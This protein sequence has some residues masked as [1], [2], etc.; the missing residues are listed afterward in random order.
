M[1][2][3]L[4]SRPGEAGQVVGGPGLAGLGMHD[5]RGLWSRFGDGLLVTV[6]TR[7]RRDEL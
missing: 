6:V 3:L 5:V 2:G 7:A 1:V 4:D